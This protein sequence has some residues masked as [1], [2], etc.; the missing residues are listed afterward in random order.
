MKKRRVILTIAALI[1]LTIAFNSCDLMS[2]KKYK[3]AI[4]QADK[5]FAEKQYESAKTFYVQAQEFEPN[6][7]YPAQKIEEINKILKAQS[8]A[9]Q[10]KKNITEA[11]QLFKQEAYN[12]AKT[13]YSKAS[14]LKTKEIYPKEQISKIDVILAEIKEQKEF[15]ANPYHIVIGCFAVEANATKLNEK[16]LSE[17][18]KSRIIPMYGG[19]YQAVTINSFTGNTAAYN[20]LNS[21]KEKFQDGAWVYK[22]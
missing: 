12:E 7:T 17:G 15:L 3:K 1:S 6:D 10:Y 2:G 14:K 16:L 13:A 22:H 4:E 8:I 5:H 19:K 9:V 11:D 20:N 21:I 18:Y